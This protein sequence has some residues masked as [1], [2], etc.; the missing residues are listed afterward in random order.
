MDP[1]GAFCTV[2]DTFDEV[3]AAKFASPV[4]AAVIV[5]VP[6]PS[7]EVEKVATALPFKVPVPRVVEP[8]LKVTIPVGV[9]LALE[10]TVAVKVA[11]SLGMDGFA[12]EISAVE[13]ALFGVAILED[14]LPPQ[15]VRPRLSKQNASSRGSLCMSTGSP[16]NDFLQTQV[17]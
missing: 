6:T 16:E 3:L 5:W 7:V 10:V 14:A 1:V 9:P 13:L 12:D 8:S 15:E 2:W 17:S 11:T 4:Y